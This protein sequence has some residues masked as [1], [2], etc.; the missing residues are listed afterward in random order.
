MG[1]GRTC[2]LNWSNTGLIQNI[3]EEGDHFED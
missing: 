2:S 3:D 1:K